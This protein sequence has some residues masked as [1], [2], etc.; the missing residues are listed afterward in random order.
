M[1]NNILNDIC[2]TGMG[3]IG[4]Q[5]YAMKWIYDSRGYVR[6]RLRLEES[7]GFDRYEYS[8]TLLGEYLWDEKNGVA[9]DRMLLVQRQEGSNDPVVMENRA[10]FQ[11]TFEKQDRDED[12]IRGMEEE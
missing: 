6:E 9:S 7:L 8:E 11:E 1:L 10:R 4:A 12:E 2:Y 5:I 3:Y